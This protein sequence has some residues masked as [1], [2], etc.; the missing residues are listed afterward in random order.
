MDR[1][2]LNNISPEEYQKQIEEV[3]YDD[4]DVFLNVNKGHSKEFHSFQS[5]AQL[6]ERLVS[7]DKEAVSSFYDEEQLR[8]SISDTIC[9]KAKEISAWFTKGRMEFAKPSEYQTLALSVDIGEDIGNGF[10][11]NYQEKA[12]SVI[13]LVL[14]RD[15]SGES[16]FGFFVN[17]AYAD[18]TNDLAYYTGKEYSKAQVL[19]N[20]DLNISPI[21]KMREEART[22]LKKDA[23]I[24]LQ[25]CNG[26]E[27]LKICFPENN[28][29]QVT[30]FLTEN[31]LSVRINSESER[32]KV[33][34][35]TCM[36]EQPD[37]ANKIGCL[38]MLSKEHSNNQYLHS[39]PTI[40]TYSPEER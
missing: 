13:T 35:D 18:I 17:T 28:E 30:V 36:I 22:I 3:S 20:D 38:Q 21:Q 24:F 12:T 16:P 7:E 26:Q 2:T 40:S 33:G 1:E 14:Q 8:Q 4:V 5:D 25:K 15:L 11:R 27:Q 31:N 32:R 29:Q 6:L 23:K 39:I 37:I 34:F 10:T 19:Q 9:Y